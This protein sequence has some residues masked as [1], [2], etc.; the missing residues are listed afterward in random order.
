[1][2]PLLILAV[3]LVATPVVA[4]QSTL[5]LSGAVGVPQSE[6]SAELGAV[7][8]GVTFG[9]LYQIPRTPVGI[10]VEATGMLF[11]YERRSEPFSLTIPDV[12]VDVTT[13]NN[14]GQGLA[15]L[16][17]QVPDGRVRPYV[18]GLA[19]VSYFWTQ[20]SVQD[21]YDDYELA[22]S[23]NYDDLA[24]TYGAGAGL[25][26]KLADSHN[27]KGHYIDVLLDGR[28]RYLVGGEATYLGRGDIDRFDNGT[29]RIYP[30]RS[31]TT[32]LVP[33]LGVTFRM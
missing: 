3:A 17:L 25:Q 7:G 12:W 10:G 18:D 19:G 20:T 11:G 4:A 6:F 22:S 2:R 30:R 5:S 32:L 23:T 26:I 28:V 14:L 29:I 24:L 27:R 16:R 33:Q 13:S 9:Y 31:T 1:M 15:V 21:F 8:G